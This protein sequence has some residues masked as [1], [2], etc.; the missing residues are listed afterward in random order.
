M[1]GFVRPTV[2]PSVCLS[3]GLLVRE[4]ESK[5]GKMSVLKLFVYV[6][7]LERVLSGVWVWMGVGHPCQ[8]VRNDIVTPR[9]LFLR[10][11][12]LSY[13]IHPS[14]LAP[15]LLPLLLLPASFSKI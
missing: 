14:I 9:H 11:S 15:I 1:R 7:V 13:H 4:H 6:S 10:L 5:S 2:H 3:V 12:Y 8:P